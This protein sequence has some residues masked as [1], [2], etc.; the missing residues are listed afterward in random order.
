MALT[1]PSTDQFFAF[2]GDEADT[3]D[4]TRATTFL[5]LAA[6]LLWLATGIDDDPADSRLN[7]LVQYAICDMAIYLYVTRD[8]IDANY[9]PFQSEHV[10]SYAYSKSYVHVS[11]QVTTGQATGVALFDRVVAYYVDQ[12]LNSG[13]GW[14]TS[15]HVF[16]Q[17]LGASRGV[18]LFDV[19]GVPMASWGS[20]QAW[21]V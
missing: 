16:Y 8:D 9:S 14:T 11:A 12:A 13:S 17:P 7:N 1:I 10:G 6:Q 18:E 15:E 20:R 3:E 2:W 21:Y 5:N 4:D 19:V